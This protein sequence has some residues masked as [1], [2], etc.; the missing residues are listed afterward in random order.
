[1]NKSE[2]EA[3]LVRVKA[4]FAVDGLKISNDAERIFNSWINGDITERQRR[5]MILE[6]NRAK[7]AKKD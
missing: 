1:M 7:I 3:V 6:V 5:E 4:L 2:R